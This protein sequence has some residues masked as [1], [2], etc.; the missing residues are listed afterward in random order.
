[1]ASDGT[2]M[3]A[4]CTPSGR[5]RRWWSR[6]ETVSAAAAVI[7]FVNVLPN[8]FCYD[9]VPIVRSNPKVNDAGQWHAIW[10]TDYW[11]EA[12]EASPNRDL[13]YRPVA[14][15]SYRLVRTVGGVNPLPHHAVNLILHVLICALV[16]RVCR[17]VGGSEAAALVAGVLFAA[18]P[19]HSEVVASVVGRAD[20]LATLCV[21]LTLQAHRRSMLSTTWRPTVSWRAAAALAVLCAM[22]S[23]EV[24]ISVVVLTL[25]FDWFL[26]HRFRETGADRHWWTWRTLMR[27]VYLMVPL[28]IYLALRYHALGGRLYQQPPLTKTVNVLVD[29]PWWQHIL[30]VLQSWGMY[31][32]KTLWPAVLSAKYS[33]NSIRLATAPMDPHV[34]I[35][36]LTLL[37]LV[38][39][40]AA[41]WRKGVRSVAFLSAG[42]VLTYLPTSN[43]IVLIQE[44]FAE[45]VWYLPSV[46]IVI[47]VGLAV[48]PVVNR[49]TWRAVLGV[50]V[51]AMM[52][53][54]WYRNAEWRDNGTLYAAAY[55]DQPDGVGPLHLY[56]QWLVRHGQYE[57]GVELLNRAIEI[58][59]GLT[60]AHR[61]L[62]EA[63][64][65][66]GNLEAA[67][68]HL[69]IADMQVPD[70]PPTAAAL[71]QV[72]RQLADA[73]EE[74]KRLRQQVDD[75]LEDVDA[76]IAL[77]RRL[78][79]LGLVTEALV[80]LGEREGR[81]ATDAAWQA[82]YA[83]TLVYLNKRDEAIGRYRK[84]LELAP[85]NP[86]LAVELCMLLLERRRGDDLDEAWRWA[87]H[88][89]RLAPGAPSVL[90]C[91]AELL[92]LRG[93]LATAATLYEQA[94]R[95]L[96][97][98]SEQRRIFE[99]RAKALGR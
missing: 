6:P 94:I 29:A 18:L 23:K 40:S 92:A 69:Q 10:T 68:Q 80:R 76:E 5:R 14:L 61:A 62:G 49:R 84:C 91:R 4:G 41:A 59:L 95:A 22:G 78:R 51:L 90:A 66:A 11:S 38:I 74:L 67:L 43:A 3:E 89:S 55:R 19:I 27:L 15:S 45:R 65:V 86:Q 35:G 79:E 46:W 36:V 97:P 52:L 42:M 30:G 47:L 26:H 21:L 71:A 75:N 25:L 33:I 24:G 72:S 60:D 37:G 81:F 20:L 98:N 17:S 88:A 96:P 57:R 48:N 58:D 77:V 44:F 13:L 34:L 39:A 1:M 31:W 87:T 2:S 83:V 56:G 64:R 28:A 7:C 32:A 16:A 53:R 63:H 82:E 70:Y 85:D 9:D 50:L 93:D 73:D 54:C 12:R 99:Q 8:E